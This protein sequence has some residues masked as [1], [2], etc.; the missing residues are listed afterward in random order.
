MNQ[1]YFFIGCSTFG[2]L[3][4]SDHLVILI[5]MKGSLLVIVV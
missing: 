5:D 2:V 4:V 1:Q 3:D